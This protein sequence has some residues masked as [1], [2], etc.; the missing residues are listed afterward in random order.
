MKLLSIKEFF[1][2]LGI[3]LEKICISKHLC[4]KLTVTELN[5]VPVYKGG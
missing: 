4:V 2:Y 1:D 5:I 3:S